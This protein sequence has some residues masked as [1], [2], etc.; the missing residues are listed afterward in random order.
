MRSE[1]D[2]NR[3][4]SR[5]Y[6]GS[7]P[8]RLPDEDDQLSQAV[9]EYNSHAKNAYAPIGLRV[10]VRNRASFYG[11]FDFSAPFSG[12]QSC[13]VGFRH[14]L[15]GVIWRRAAHDDDVLRFFHSHSSPLH[16]CLGWQIRSTGSRSTRIS[17]L[18]VHCQTATTWT[19]ITSASSATA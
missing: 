6:S 17:P 7:R 3:R 19:R 10:Q 16:T 13:R 8:F 15:K 2:S 18:A 5:R 9:L 11:L 1:W 14:P 4:Y 12:V